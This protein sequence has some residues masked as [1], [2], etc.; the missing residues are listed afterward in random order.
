VKPTRKVMPSMNAL[1]RI[2]N[3]AKIL[4][5]FICIEG[6]PIPKK[7][8]TFETG[9][10][11]FDFVTVLQPVWRSSRISSQILTETLP[12]FGAACVTKITGLCVH[13]WIGAG[14]VGRAIVIDGQT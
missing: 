12:E 10:S 9:M 8:R 5:N 1:L 13:Q 14:R 4:L 11:Q 3:I 2:R 7:I 6:H